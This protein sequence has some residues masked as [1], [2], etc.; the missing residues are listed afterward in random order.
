MQPNTS[1]AALSPR[2]PWAF[3]CSC[4]FAAYYTTFP[5]TSSTRST[6]STR[7]SSSLFGATGSDLIAT[8][9]CHSSF[10]IPP[11]H[12]LSPRGVCSRIPH[13]RRISRDSHGQISTHVYILHIIPFLGCPPHSPPTP[14]EPI[15]TAANPSRDSQPTI[16]FP[17]T[18]LHAI[19][20]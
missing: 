2:F 7:P 17:L 6:C 11:Q 15:P 18:I 12:T 13:P 5:Y 9:N 19:H 10:R 20:S 16:F 1:L 8:V 14:A 3:H 4:L